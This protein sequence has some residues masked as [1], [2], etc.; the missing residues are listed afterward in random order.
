M[1]NSIYTAFFLPPFLEKKYI[2]HQDDKML[3]FLLIVFYLSWLEKQ[4]KKE[5]VSAVL[6]NNSDYLD[7]LRVEVAVDA[8]CGP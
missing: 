5:K 3:S 1:D 8:R 2:F 7:Y 6:I 4:G